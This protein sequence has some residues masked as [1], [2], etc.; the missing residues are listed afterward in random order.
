MIRRIL[1]VDDSPIS[2]KIL[3][4]CLPKEREFEILEAGDGAA[5]VAMYKEQQPDLTFMDL[6]MPVMD[7]VQ[8][9]A[10]IIEYNGKAK[11]VVCT[12]DIQIKSINRVLEIGACHVLKKPPTREAVLNALTMVEQCDG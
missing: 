12:A 2:R 10:E 8:A 6:T 7:G 11:V 9:L 4:S 3:K 5:G 1:I